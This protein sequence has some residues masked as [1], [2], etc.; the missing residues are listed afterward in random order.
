MAS[1]LEHFGL[2]NG[3]QNRA[4]TRREPPRYPLGPPRDAQGPPGPPRSPQEPKNEAKIDILE[5]K[6]V[7]LGAILVT[8]GTHFNYFLHLTTFGTPDRDK[9][10]KTEHILDVRLILQ[11]WDTSLRPL[12]QKQTKTVRLKC[13]SQSAQ[14]KNNGAAV[15][16]RVTQ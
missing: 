12:I 11:I 6:I 2:Q 10:E 14:I 9:K 13:L 8:F 5:A 7:I 16:P 1:F 15:S 3:A 4:K